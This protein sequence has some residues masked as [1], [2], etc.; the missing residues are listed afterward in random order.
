MNNLI[1][2]LI[3]F[4]IGSG[5]V[6][7]EEITENQI[8]VLDNAYSKARLVVA[9]RC[10]IGAEYAR[11]IAIQRDV[12]VPYQGIVE[13]VIKSAERDIE[14]KLEPSLKTV[15]VLNNLLLVT[16]VYTNQNISADDIY[17]QQYIYCSGLYMRTLTLTYDFIKPE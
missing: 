8:T 2:F 7:G 12:G 1:I 14:E 13:W 9:A 16:L 15:D 4:V 10:A 17:E 6:V 3:S 5:T 11:K